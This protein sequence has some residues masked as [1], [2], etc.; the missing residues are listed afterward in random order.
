MSIKEAQLSNSDDEINIQKCKNNNQDIKE[1][2]NII[3]FQE[4]EN[5]KHTSS[6]NSN[7]NDSLFEELKIKENKNNENLKSISNNSKNIG[8]NLVLFS[9]YVCGSTDC[10]W[11]LILIII[12]IT[13]SW[14]L[15]VYFLG[16]FYSKLV[17]IYIG[18]YLLATDYYMIL[19]YITE[20]GIIPKNH[21]DFLKPKV[22]NEDENI[23][24]ITPRI[25]TERKCSTCNIFRPPKA[26]H[27]R[28][29]DNCVMDFDHHC[30]FISNCIGKRNH[31]YFYLFL[32]FGSILSLHCILLNI[33]TVV[34]VFIIKYNLT[35]RLLFQGN[36]YLFILIVILMIISILYSM[37]PFAFCFS[38]FFGL[39]GF[40]LFL[41]MWFKYV[42]IK[43]NTP[44]YFNP[45]II[46]TLIIA[47][48][49]GFFVI[50]SFCS[51]T[52][53]VSQK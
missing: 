28:T 10:L 29:C 44:S 2:N 50:I 13:I 14:I 47:L 49:F 38:I 35:T 16:R 18:F 20:P 23:N 11:L 46:I 43:E 17:Y 36:K 5:L 40:S 9:K 6:T 15:W 37:N 7:L 22:K 53:S 26:S 41:V 3:S 25:F 24:K 21:P 32:L 19:S 1:E 39:I 45:F 31:K 34:Y 4:N 42:P 52:Y 51:Q 12:L 48:I 8:N 33:I 27:C 30:A